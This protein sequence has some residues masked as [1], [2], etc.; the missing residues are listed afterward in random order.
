M[1]K[2]TIEMLRKIKGFQQISVSYIQKTFS[3]GYK[4]ATS[5]YQELINNAFIDNKGKPILEKIYPAIG[6]DNNP[7]MNIIFLDVDGVLNCHSTKD[8]CGRYI[9][10]DDEKVILLKELI[11]KTNAVVVLVSSWKEYWYKEKRL[12]R[13][14]NKSANYLDE[15]LKKQGITIFDK[16]EDSNCFFRGEGV[17]SYLE[18]LSKKGIVVNNFIILDDEV[19]DYKEMKLTPNFVQTSFYQN[20]LEKKHIK[21]AI[22][23][24]KGNQAL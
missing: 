20:G 6:E 21:K 19:W 24:L 15:K 13:A 12:K 10:I 5:I 17:V 9:G 1:D 22:I 14:Q 3:F 7:R 23:K 8:R 18:K 4:K 11:D 16:T 2:I